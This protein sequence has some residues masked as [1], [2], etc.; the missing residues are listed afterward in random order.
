[1]EIEI[2]IDKFYPN[3]F[4]ITARDAATKMTEKVAEDPGAWAEGVALTR[5]DVMERA[6]SDEAE[7][8]FKTA[9]MAVLNDKLRQAG[10][11]EVTT[12][13]WKRLV[14][15]KSGSWASGVD[16]KKDKIIAKVADAIAVTYEVA[17]EVRGMA[18]GLPGSPASKA[19]M[20]KYFDGR[21]AAKKAKGT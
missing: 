13:E 4:P 14:E 5:V 21:V 1:M 18:K 3:P 7:A 19:R 6:R 17:E 2:D 10:L 8:N 15:A 9:M 20:V 16:A 12:T 11:A